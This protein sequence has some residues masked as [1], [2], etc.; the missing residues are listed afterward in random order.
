MFS[1]RLLFAVVILGG[2]DFWVAAMIWGYEFLLW[3][4]C[5][6]KES[7]GLRREGLV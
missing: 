4:P 3:H 6:F 7:V 5:K 2:D 1:E